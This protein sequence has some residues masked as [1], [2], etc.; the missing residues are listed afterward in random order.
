MVGGLSEGPSLRFGMTA[1]FWE[2]KDFSSRNVFFNHK[3]FSRSSK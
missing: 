3:L 1:T 2:T